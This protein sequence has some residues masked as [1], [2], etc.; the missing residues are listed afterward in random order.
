MACWIRKKGN[1][2]SRYLL[3]AGVPEVD[4]LNLQQDPH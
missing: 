1:P 2:L 3:V 4:Q